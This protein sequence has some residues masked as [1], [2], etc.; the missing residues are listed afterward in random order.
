MA[1][2]VTFTYDGIGSEESLTGLADELGDEITVAALP[3]RGYT[4]TMWSDMSTL[5]DALLNVQTLV[6]TL[7]DPVGVAVVTE[8]E[9][10]RGSRTRRHCRRS[11]PR[12][13]LPAC[14]G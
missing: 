3:G 4:V 8:A 11:C 1:Q 6:K 13:R 12:S 5:V 2:V 7:P 14:W 10:E 9:Y